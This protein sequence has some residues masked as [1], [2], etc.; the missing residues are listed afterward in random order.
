M[1]CKYRVERHC[2]DDISNIEDYDKADNTEIWRPV[3][4]YEGLY[5][6]SDQGRVRSL[7]SGK[8]R[9]RRI[10]KLGKNP[11]GYLYVKLCKDGKGEGMRVHR[12]VAEAFIPNPNHLAT[13]NHKDEDKTNNFASNL[14]WMSH[15]D[16]I[17][18]GSHNR[19]MAEALAK[20]M[21]GVNVNNPKLSKPVQQL[22]KATGKV[23]AA[24]PSTVEAERITGIAHSSICAC[25]NGKCKSA[26]GYVWRYK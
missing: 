23:L 8:W 15:K 14:E 20:A 10:L 24:F 19:R 5:E 4:G 21:A 16:N 3:V 25:C 13:V 26:G 2:S 11:N 17:N 18:Y 12:V 9:N 1:T 7:Q 22:D 6:V